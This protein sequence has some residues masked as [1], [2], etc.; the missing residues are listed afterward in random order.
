MRRAA[1]S[2]ILAVQIGSPPGMSAQNSQAWDSRF[3]AIPDAKTIGEHMRRLT[4]RPHHVGSPYDKDN[5][6]WILGRFRD[7]GW[8]ARIDTYQ[9]LFPTPKERVLDMVA[10]TPFKAALR[11]P[12]IA[13]DPTSN[14]TAEQIPSYN[15]YSIDGDV[16]A[17]LVYVNYGRPVDYEELDREGIS[18]RGAIVIARYGASWRGI[19]PKVAAEHGAVGCLLYSDPRD[20]GYWVGEAF[21]NG[22]M[23]NKDGAQRGSVG[24]M[25]L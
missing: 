15:A 21:P 16:T 4:A 14:Q 18:V 20:D 23:R 3:R 25:P 13:A 11:E 6:E 7:W 22:P 19:K 2:A 8:D 17:P 10:P 5:A 12:P 9:V 24:D 1:V